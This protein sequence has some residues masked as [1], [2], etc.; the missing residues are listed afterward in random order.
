[1]PINRNFWT[2]GRLAVVRTT[3]P[4]TD[5]KLRPDEIGADPEKLAKYADVVKIGRKTLLTERMVERVNKAL[6][7]CRSVIYE[8]GTAFPIGALWFIPTQSI[9]VVKEE[10]TTAHDELVAAVAELK[11]RFPDFKASMIVLY[12][13]LLR[14]EDF[15][16]CESKLINIDA[17]LSMFTLDLDSQPVEEAKSLLEAFGEQTTRDGRETLMTR[18]LSL[19]DFLGK[20]T[21]SEKS[22]NSTKRFLERARN[23][24][25]VADPVL[26]AALDRLS[27][28]LDRRS[29]KKL[30]EVPAEADAFRRAL[31][32]IVAEVQ[33]DTDIPGLISGFLDRAIE[34]DVPA[35]TDTGTVEPE[36]AMA[37][38]TELIPVAV[39]GEQR[40]LEL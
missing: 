3:V 7:R 11:D 4:I 33:V 28:E 30:R 17:S 25:I 32:L 5:T 40:A 29:A 20:G 10:F 26:N 1:M 18:A 36:P 19:V 37:T 12:P 2:Q 24:N 9:D 22:L 8:H 23:A 16:R 35:A 38:V 39:A 21:I 34:M 15:M 27:G 31:D 6:S 14:D 13:D